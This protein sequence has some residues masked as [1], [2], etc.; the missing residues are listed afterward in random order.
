MSKLKP[1]VDLGYPTEAHG[2]IP[3][4][5]NIKEEA[6]FW[7]THDSTEY[8]DEVEPIRL[9]RQQPVW[10][11]VVSLSEQ[12]MRSLESAAS[13]EGVTSSTIAQRWIAERLRQERRQQFATLPEV[14]HGA[15]D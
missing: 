14:E 3:S 12:E 9:A 2:D 6:E 11:L 7:D 1:T 4:F 5:A 15:A 8:L 13:E 10:R